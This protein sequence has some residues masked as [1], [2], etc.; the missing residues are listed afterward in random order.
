MQSQQ[1]CG[2]ELKHVR[3]CQDAKIVTYL[4]CSICGNMT[5]CLVYCMVTG[6]DSLP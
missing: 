3:R 5:P 4:R 2:G 1:L 6:K